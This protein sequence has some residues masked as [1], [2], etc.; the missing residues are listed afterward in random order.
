MSILSANCNLK[1]LLQVAGFSFILKEGKNRGKK[2][3]GNTGKMVIILF[4]SITLTSLNG[5]ETPTKLCQA[6]AKMS[7]NKPPEKLYI[8][9]HTTEIKC[10]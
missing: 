4:R 5:S 9:A 3:T 2:L 6:H 7:K 1:K 10:P 8:L